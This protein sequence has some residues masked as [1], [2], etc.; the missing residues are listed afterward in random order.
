MAKFGLLPVGVFLWMRGKLDAT[1][2]LKVMLTQLMCR[3]TDGQDFTAQ[4]EGMN[5]EG[6][7]STVLEDGL[8]LCAL[9]QE[10]PR[11]QGHF[12]LQSLRKPIIRAV[13]RVNH[14][15]IMKP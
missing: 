15:T 11:I 1:Q 12:K 2:E 9:I 6:P 3:L 10:H 4:Y 14:L 7:A 8:S 13:G 5:G